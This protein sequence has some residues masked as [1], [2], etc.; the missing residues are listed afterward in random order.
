MMGILFTLAQYSAGGAWITFILGPLLAHFRALPP[1]QGFFLMLLSAPFGVFAIL[2]AVTV[3]IYAPHAAS[4]VMAVG[5]F[6][7]VPVLFFVPSILSGA[8]YPIINDISSNLED[9]P[10]FVAALARSENSGRD[11]SFPQAFGEP[12]RKAYADLQPLHFRGVSFSKVRAKAEQIVSARE[13]WKIDGIT[14]E[15]RIEGTSES[16][17]FRFQDD[18]V[19][20][21]RSVGETAETGEVIVDM[22]SKSRDGKGDLGVNAKRIRDFFKE[23]SHEMNPSHSAGS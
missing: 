20:R 18:W 5:I 16:M 9:P 12:V 2:G 3:K 13:G 4:R 21:L 8:K 7:L 17:L 1:V 14:D 22:R 10:A 15:N 11:L 23:L 19:I 6:G